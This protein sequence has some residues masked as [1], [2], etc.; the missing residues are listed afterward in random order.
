VSSLVTADFAAKTSALSSQA[1]TLTSQISGVSSLK[2][3]VSDFATALA[4]L[5]KGGTLT[6]QPT[7]SDANVLTATALSGAKLSGLSSTIKVSQLASAQIAVSAHAFASSTATIGTGTLTLALGTASYSSDG[8]SMTDFTAQSGDPVTIDVTD[9]SLSGIAAAI[10]AKKTGVNASVVTDAD[11]TAYLSLKGTT[12]AAQAFTLTGST[13]ALSALNVGKDAAGTTMTSVAQ[14]AKLTVDGVAVERTSNTISDLV[15]GVKLSLTGTSA[16][17]VA[18]GSSTPTAA[19]SSAV[20]DV[21]DTYNQVIALVNAQ[22]DPITGPLKQ[23]SAAK[24][25]LSSMRGL[26]QKAL[27]TN[28][29]AGTPTSLA[30]IGV[31]TNKDGTLQVDTDALTAAMASYPD[32]IEQM[33]AF[34]SNGSSGLSAVL[35]SLSLATSSTLTGLGA[36]SATYVKKQSQVSAQQD[37]LTTDKTAETT[38][39][40]AQFASMNSKVAAYKS[41]QTFLTNQIAAWNKSDS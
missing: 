13:P 33:F 10:N 32:T 38:R 1:D 23:D 34:S 14:N 41:T 22:V 18:L 25:L 36:S 29:D 39:L 12:G 19:L 35:N 2:S 20:S 24:A 8:S 40:T 31:R 6:T 28:V 17:P 5:V 21:V 16:V 26:T 4:S 27:L 30:G 11:G 37:E 3:S 9:G 15:T 7:S